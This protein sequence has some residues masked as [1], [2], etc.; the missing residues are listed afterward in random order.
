MKRP[1]ALRA[2][3]F[4]QQAR[5]LLAERLID[6]DLADPDGNAVGIAREAIDRLQPELFLKLYRV[7]LGYSPSDVDPEW[8]AKQQ[9]EFA[10]DAREAEAAGKT[11]GEVRL[12][13]HE[14]N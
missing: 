3:Q 12:E 13:R 5:E 11:V 2:V 10:A 6:W 1:N 7:V 14:K 9:E 8:P 4:D